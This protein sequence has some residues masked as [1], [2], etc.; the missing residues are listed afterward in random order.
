MDSEQSF[1]MERL[2][3]M[4]ASAPSHIRKG[5]I[6]GLRA[7]WS[8]DPS[9]PAFHT[10]P[11]RK[12]FQALS[13]FERIQH[14]DSSPPSLPRVPFRENAESPRVST[15]GSM[16]GG[17]GGADEPD[18]QAIVSELPPVDRGRGAWTYL[19][20]A[21]LVEGLCWGEIVCYVV[22]VLFPDTDFL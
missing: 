21:F 2:V 16:M 17:F 8:H 14:V 22:K 11:Q 9:A 5:P 6:P 4:G 1:N 19:L 3:P 18:N 20:V 12:S 15:T 10:E 7:T 13:D